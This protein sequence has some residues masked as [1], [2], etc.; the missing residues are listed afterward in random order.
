[1]TVYCKADTFASWQYGTSPYL[2]FPYQWHERYKA[3]EKYGINGTL[4]SWSS[5]YTPNFMT[6]L[7][8]WTCWTD[9]PPFEDLLGQTA[10]LYFGDANK[11]LVLKAW[12][13]FSRAIRLV[14]DTGP[15][16]GTNNAVG[17]PI[18]LK[19]PPLRTMTF[20]R[21]WTD[22]DKWTGYL[23]AQINPY[24]PFTVTRMVFYPDFTNAVNMAELYA[25]SATGVET[26]PE[27]RLLPMF[28]DYLSRAAAE[29]ETG[30]QAYRAAALTS[31]P[32]KRQGALGEVIIAEQLQ[33]M[34]QHDGATLA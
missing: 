28:L 5:G 30:L 2:P 11:D 34:M 17:N 21:S 7:R 3:L 25:R 14:L 10:A 9:A 16:F 8:A 26:G 13:H 18:F 6:H 27:T 19:E 31:P 32:E 33:R 29:M 24:W 20:T 23:G 15:N 22:H 12:D 4:E 1:M